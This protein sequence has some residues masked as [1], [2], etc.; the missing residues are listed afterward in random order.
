L[1]NVLEHVA[2]EAD[3]QEKYVETPSPPGP[4]FWEKKTIL[5]PDASPSSIILRGRSTKP[6]TPCQDSIRDPSQE[7]R[8]PP[9]DN[10]D[11]L[12]RSRTSAA[13]PRAQA[14]SVC[15]RP[16]NPHIRSTLEL[17]EKVRDSRYKRRLGEY[18]SQTKLLPNEYKQLLKLI[19][20]SEDVGLR[21]Y[22]DDKL[23]YE[24]LLSKHAEV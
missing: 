12:A 1:I 3:G 17:I 19:K 24:D 20:D 2:E 22:F 9:S 8:G 7:A 21:T 13:A 14:R 15:R 11:N 6:R 5:T 10:A 18:Y 23:R 4:S 16:S